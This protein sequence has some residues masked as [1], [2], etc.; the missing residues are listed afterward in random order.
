MWTGTEGDS[1]SFSI[2]WGTGQILTKGDLNH[3]NAD[4]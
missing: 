2:D 4:M 3:E 1:A